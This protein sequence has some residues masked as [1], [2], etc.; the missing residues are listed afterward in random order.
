MA[1]YRSEE[2]EESVRRAAAVSAQTRREHAQERREARAR[3]D[4]CVA[5]GQLPLHHETCR[6]DGCV[7]G[8][9]RVAAGVVPERTTA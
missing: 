9:A 5:R 1:S 6:C 4:A 8:M 3:R 7:A 2:Q